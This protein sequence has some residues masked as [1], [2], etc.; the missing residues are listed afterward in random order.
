MALDKQTSEL[1]ESLFNFIKEKYKF[2]QDPE[3]HFHEDE[4]NAQNVLGYTGYYD[5]KSKSVN[6]FITARHPKDVLRSFAHELMHHVQEFEGMNSDHDMKVTR[7]PN[8]IMK[9]KHMEM[10]EADAFER[11]NVT[12]R[13]WEAYQKG[14]KDDKDEVKETKVPKKGKKHDQFKAGMQKFE[15]AVSK[16]DFTKKYGK[17]QG[18]R[19]YYAT[20]TN[21]GKKKAHLKEGVEMSENVKKQEVREVEV[22]EALKDAHAYLP[23]ERV[24]GEA[25]NNREEKVYNELLKKF[26]IKK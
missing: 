22:N 18:E 4:K 10:I 8:Y 7:D 24:C 5:P 17:E 11:G 23:E 12:F 13:Q 20:A 2:D 3:V 9:D 14:F 16:K 25:Y 15:K 1:A 19:I 21:A 26:G 6:V